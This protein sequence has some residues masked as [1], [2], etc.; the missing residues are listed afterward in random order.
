MGSSLAALIALVALAASIL[1]V[2]TTPREEPRPNGIDLSSLYDH[3]LASR[4]NGVEIDLVGHPFYEVPMPEPTSCRPPELDMGSDESWEE[5]AT[6]A[7][8]CLDRLW[9][10]VLEEL[11]LTGRTP[12][13]A[14]TRTSPDEDDEESYTLAYYESDFARIT[15]VLPNVRYV[16]A[17]VPADHREDVWLALMGHEYGH[18]VQHLTGILDVS[19]D[20]R[21][22]AGN[23]DEELDTLRRTELQ[24]ECLAGV[25]LRG[26]TDAER[27]RLEAVNANFNDGG[28]LETHGSARNR[29]LWLERGWSGPTLGACNTYDAEPDQVA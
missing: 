10:P 19:Y 4:P 22:N 16:G 6:A 25:G 11:G 24:A 20:L 9:A 13:F 17:L 7:G 29:A 12:E 2:L 27:N 21:W 26:I 28:D 14:V 15:V 5:F 3:R 1:M 18:H 8:T 23:A